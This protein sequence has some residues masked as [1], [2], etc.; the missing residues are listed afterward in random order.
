MHK[1]IQSISRN[2]GY[3]N[4]GKKYYSRIGA[5]INRYGTSAILHAIKDVSS[6]NESN[7]THLLNIIEKRCQKNINDN[8]S[9][10]DW[11]DI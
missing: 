5:M 10:F 9:E 3:G 7:L 8:K 11:N 1:V 2:F 4:I 6:A